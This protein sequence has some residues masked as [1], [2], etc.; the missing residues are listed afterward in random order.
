M[1]RLSIANVGI[2]AGMN[3]FSFSRGDPFSL[4]DFRYV[5]GQGSLA[6]GV[7]EGVLQNRVLSVN[8]SQG[9]KGHAG[10][11]GEMFHGFEVSNWGL[12]DVFWKKQ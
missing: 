4:T 3:N 9:A 11:N 1:G 2:I 7:G 12:E 10:Q 5:S 6:V 8:S